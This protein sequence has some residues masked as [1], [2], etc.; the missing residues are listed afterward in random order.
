MPPVARP[1]VERF[2]PYVERDKESGC[3]NWTGARV[4]GHGR[5]ALTT[6][7]QVMAHRFAWELEHGPI[8]DELVIDHLCKNRACVNTAHLEVVTSGENSRRAL[9]GIPHAP[10]PFCKRGHAMTQVNT[11][12]VRIDGYTKRRC[13]SCQAMHAKAWRNRNLESEQHKTRTRMFRW[14]Q[15]H[16]E[17]ARRRERDAKRRARAAAKAEAE[18][19]TPVN[20]RNDFAYTA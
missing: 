7:K 1:A 18:C 3:M 10:K 8:P 19:M 13:K 4:E 15:E 16:L 11:L 20:G 6:S 2:W 14:R 9:I 17:E 5:F 12:V